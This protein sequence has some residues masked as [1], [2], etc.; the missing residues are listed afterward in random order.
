M[1][2]GPSFDHRCRWRPSERAPTSAR[3]ESP[4]RSRTPG[5]GRGRRRLRCRR[6]WLSGIRSRPISR[7]MRTF[8]FIDMPS[9]ATVRS[10]EIG[11][12]GDLLDAVDVAGEAGGDDAAT[13]V[14]VEQVEQHLADR[15][16]DRE[17]PR[18]S[19]L[20]ESD[21][22]RRM[23]SFWAMAPMTPRSVS[24][25]STGV[26]SSLKSPVCRIVPCG[27]W[28]AVAKPCGTEWVTGMNSQSNGPIRRRSPSSTG[29]SSVRS[30]RPPP[31]CDCGPG[32]ASGPIRRSG[33]TARAADRPSRRA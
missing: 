13:R 21:S 26:R 32:R 9:V 28:N 23:P 15:F 4:W 2:S 31:R 27:V 20:V 8:F 3:P 10:N 12:V 33:R 22:S 18:A 1:S 5:R 16:S 24:R 30:S 19:A 6:R 29:I 17:W 14:G 11:G 25:P 7:A